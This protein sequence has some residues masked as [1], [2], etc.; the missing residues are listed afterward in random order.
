MENWTRGFKEINVLRCLTCLLF[1]PLI[2]TPLLKF[3]DDSLTALGKVTT[4]ASCPLIKFTL[5]I[6]SH[7]LLLLL[8]S[9]VALFAYRWN[10]NA[11]EITVYI[12][13]AT[14]LIF[15]IREVDQSGLL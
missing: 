2:F 13:I 4:F 11:W 8:Y 9:F 5:A 10:I 1:L 12:W 7:I 14:V 3:K 6:I 15:E